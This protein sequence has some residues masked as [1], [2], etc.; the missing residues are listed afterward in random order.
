MKSATFDLVLFEPL[1]SLILTNATD[2]E[3]WKSLLQFA[4]T[5]E[6]IF[7]SQEKKE[8]S[9]D[10]KSV[11][12]RAGTTQ[13]CTEQKME[14]LKILL[15][16]ELHSSVY[17]NVQGFWRI[18]F[19]KKLWEDNCIGLAKEYVKRSAEDGFKFPETPTE[20]L[21]WNLMKAV[22]KKIFES[23]SKTC[24]TL[25]T[26]SSSTS[27]GDEQYLNKTQ[28]Q[29]TKTSKFDGGQ[30]ARQVDYFIKRR[31]LPTSKRHHWRDVL[32]VGELIESTQTMF[33][34]KFLQLSVLM[35]ELFFAQPFR[36]FAHAF[37]LFNKS[38]LL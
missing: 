23:S 6:L 5:L 26:A 28:F 34:D 15:R 29:T 2:I 18:H 31:G 12:R 24:A 20:K 30:T 27:G 7:K 37:H 13:A 35:R 11:F 4:D 25:T 16:K 33:M 3:V 8:E 21:A 14:K 22:E 38:L 17:L 1:A 36:R 9:L 10:A 19:T 32:V